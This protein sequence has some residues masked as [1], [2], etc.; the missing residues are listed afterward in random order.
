MSEQEAI[1]ELIAKC[2]ELYINPLQDQI[3]ELRRMVEKL[4]HEAKW[5]RHLVGDN[6][7]TNFPITEEPQKGDVEIDHEVIEFFSALGHHDKTSGDST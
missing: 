4:E 7:I 5:H 2:V 6:E 1:M 3:T